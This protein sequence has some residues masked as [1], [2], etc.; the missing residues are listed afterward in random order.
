MIRAKWGAKDVY[1]STTNA[2]RRGVLTLLH[3]RLDATILHEVK[4]DNG[5]FHILVARIRSEDYMLINV[6]G[7]P[8]T[9]REAEAVMTELSRNLEQVTQAHVIHHT[10]MAGDFNFVLHD[11]DTTSHTRRPRAEAMCTTIINFHDLYDVAAL[12]SNVPQHT[13]F[14]HRMERTSARYDRI[15]CSAGLLA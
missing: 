10:I 6:Y 15:Y 12:Q 1:M 13:Y 11:M 5:Q 8:D 4:D 9:D 3:P 7:A 2:P 14:R